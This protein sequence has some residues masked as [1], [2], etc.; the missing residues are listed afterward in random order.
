MAAGALAASLAACGGEQEGPVTR[1]GDGTTATS[2]GASDGASG[3]TSDGADG[4]RGSGSPEEQPQAPV[5]HDLLTVVSTTLGGGTVDEQAVDLT[6]PGGVEEL[7]AGLDAG[8]PARVW[9][10]VRRERRRPAVQEA[11][12]GGA[13]LY[14]AVVWIGCETP[15][16]IV[17]RRGDAGLEARAVVKST[18]TV[19]CLAPVTS[20]AVFTA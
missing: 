5:E 1:P 13:D 18:G 20:V 2:D 16:E 14:G 7:V 15:D 6:E 4:A 8:M 3:G 9:H 10:V 11:L 12:S 19:Q 17:V